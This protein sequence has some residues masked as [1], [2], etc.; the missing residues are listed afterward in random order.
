MRKLT[1]L[2]V[3]VSGCATNSGI[4]HI[5][6]GMHVATADSV[7]GCRLLGDVHGVSGL[8]GVFAGAALSGARQNAFEQAQAMGANT[9]VWTQFNTPYGSTSVAGNAYSCSAG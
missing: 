6:A 1:I 9:I 7:Y 2:T 4:S 8:Y 3:L 5:P